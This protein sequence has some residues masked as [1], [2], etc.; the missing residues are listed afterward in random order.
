MSLK[1]SYQ[2][3]SKYTRG[4]KRARTMDSE[5]SK[6]KKQVSKNKKELKYY[7]GYIRSLISTNPASNQS[8]L[9]DVYESDGITPRN[10][11]FVGRKIYVHKIEIRNTMVT[12]NNAPTN[13]LLW[14]EKRQ[15]KNIT[16]GAMPPLAIDPEYH[17]L[18]RYLDL[19]EDFET[20]SGVTVAITKFF[21][22]YVN[23]GSQGR[24]VE[25]DDQVTATA[26]G[27]VV[28]GD[29]KCTYFRDTDPSA[30]GFTNTQIRVW[31]RDG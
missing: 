11:T 18:L 17:T 31:Y 6:L 2:V 22:N 20:N 23:F 1:R 10:P 12:D 26:S 13:F 8:L 5:L 14:R 15:G 7:D 3:Q 28:S 16:A 4:S 19:A 9:T 27:N 24:L 29:I 25:F 30:I 21:H